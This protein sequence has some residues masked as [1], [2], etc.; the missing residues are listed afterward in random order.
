MDKEELRER[1]EAFGEESVCA[2]AGRAA[3]SCYDRAIAADPGYDKPHWQLISALAALGEAG[4]AV[5]RY[6]QLVAE[7]PGEPR[8]YRF[9]RLRMPVRR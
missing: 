7:A 6:R 5:A 8:G 4:Q 3:A 1:Y 2:E 9:P